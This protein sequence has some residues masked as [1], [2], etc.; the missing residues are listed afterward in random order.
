MH[1]NTRVVIGTA[2]TAIASCAVLAATTLIWIAATDPLWMVTLVAR[3][4]T[5]IW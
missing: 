2:A 1:V 4:L 5:G 3:V